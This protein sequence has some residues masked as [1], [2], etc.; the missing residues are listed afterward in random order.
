MTTRTKDA[1]IIALVI[2]G[3]LAIAVGD[4]HRIILREVVPVLNAY[5]D[6]L[7]R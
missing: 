6:Y 1:A 5:L 3:T 2:I 4:L 7:V